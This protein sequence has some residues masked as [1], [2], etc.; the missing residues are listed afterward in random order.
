M[1]NLLEPDKEMAL[2]FLNKLDPSKPTFTF[3]TFYDK[4]DEN[5]F[6]YPCVKHGTFYE[7]YELL[8]KLNQK[9]AGI[10]VM[11]NRGDGIMHEGEKT[12][13]TKSNVI[14]VRAL[15]ADADGVPIEPILEIC[16]PPHIL[17]ESS[18][19][20]WHIYWLTN[21][22]KLEEFTPMQEAIAERYGTDPAVKDLPRVMRIPGFYHQ[23][24]EPFMTRLVTN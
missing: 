14:A 18:P 8:K 12:C 4:K 21:D 23:K 15:F 3:Q 9:G 2:R 7:H 1:T 6:I 24:N 13:R 11:V 5:N 20:K 17:V 16:P 10:F 19:G 22:T